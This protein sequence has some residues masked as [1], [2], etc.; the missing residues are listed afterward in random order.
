MNPASLNDYSLTT[1]EDREIP[2]MMAEE[3]TTVE[4]VQVLTKEII[5]LEDLEKATLG[6]S[7]R[8]KNQSTKGK[9]GFLTTLKRA[10]KMML[11][12]ARDWCT[13][14]NQSRFRVEGTGVEPQ[15]IE[16]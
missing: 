7:T 1:L 15:L 6:M 8:E 11:L 14:V 2:E 12:T 10:I 9:V 5:E 13:R 4:L 3:T 16:Q